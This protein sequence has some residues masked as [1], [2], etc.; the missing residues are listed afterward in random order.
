V[1]RFIFK[2]TYSALGTVKE[3]IFTVENDLPKI[4]KLLTS[5]GYSTS[6]CE[7]NTLIGVEVFGIKAEDPCLK[8]IMKSNCVKNDID[9][10]H[11]CGIFLNYV[12]EKQK[13]AINE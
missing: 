6:G 12:K 4:E 5:G 1:I 2:N 8:C 3:Q 9:R 13:E 10:R 11:E 7:F